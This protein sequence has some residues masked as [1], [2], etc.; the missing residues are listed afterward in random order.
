V[1]GSCA[2]MLIGSAPRRKPAA[3]R[4]TIGSKFRGSY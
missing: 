3:A 2:F 1:L 4:H